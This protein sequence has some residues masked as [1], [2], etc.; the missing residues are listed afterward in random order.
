MFACSRNRSPPKVR[1]KKV[2]NHQKYEALF[3]RNKRF[4]GIE[5]EHHTC[6]GTTSRN[7]FKPLNPPPFSLN[8]VQKNSSTR[9]TPTN[10]LQRDDHGEHSMKTIT[11][12]T[13]TMKKDEELLPAYEKK[14]DGSI[15]TRNL[16]PTGNLIPSSAVPTREDTRDAAMLLTSIRNIV[17]EKELEL[18]HT[19][20]LPPPP[21]S[22]SL[23]TPCFEKHFKRDG[24][25]KKENVLSDTPRSTSTD[26]FSSLKSQQHLTES[27]F[28]SFF[29][30]ARARAV[31]VDSHCFSSQASG[32]VPRQP[33]VDLVNI[34]GALDNMRDHQDDRPAYISPPSS[35]TLHPKVAPLI[36]DIAGKRDR[37][38]ADRRKRYLEEYSGSSFNADSDTDGVIS[39]TSREI[40]QASA[41]AS[42]SCQKLNKR[43][44]VTSRPIHNRKAAKRELKK[45][46]N[47]NSSP[48][49][50]KSSKNV[51]PKAILRK[52]FSWKNFPELES[53][54]IENREEYLRHSALNY[55]MQQKQYNNHLTERLIALATECNYEFDDKVFTFVT[56]RDRIRCYF[57]SYVQS[58]KKRGVIIGYAARK[59][60]LL[61]GKELEKETTTSAISSPR[62]LKRKR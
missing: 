17:V 27:S 46:T 41:P 15:C 55:T 23:F 9:Y 53:F 14:E 52:K 5:I 32:S 57:K 38:V 13:T 21:Q 8:N 33:V 2:E 30:N 61:A 6:A 18:D 20:H 4:A 62:S 43:P 11:P 26:T 35:P 50:M 7:S 51:K 19:I 36:S 49:S 3:S 39:D 10:D 42:A 34:G 44:L 59:A 58:R 31:S 16:I 54:L 24:S 1:V 48:L 12:A 40:P 25:K 47:S 22:A 28:S 45:S 60:G 37:R 29:L 56:I